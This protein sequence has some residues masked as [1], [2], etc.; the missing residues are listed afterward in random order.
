MATPEEDAI[1]TAYREAVAQMYTMALSNVT[2]VS[3]EAREGE[4]A[5]ATGRFR[6]GLGLARRVRD[7]LKQ[8]VR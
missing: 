1:D 4:I 5:D 2:S 7:A 6:V 3:N 8:V